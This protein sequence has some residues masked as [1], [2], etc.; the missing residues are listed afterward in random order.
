M[1]ASPLQLWR[2]PC[3]HRIKHRLGVGEPALEPKRTG[4]L[5]LQLQEVGTVA[6]PLRLRHEVTESR[7]GLSR[8]VEIPQ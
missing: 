5:G 6:E 4:Y 3:L 8:L 7:L 2:Y 1:N